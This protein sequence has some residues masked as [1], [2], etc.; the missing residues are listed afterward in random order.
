[1]HNIIFTQYC[2]IAGVG[3]NTRSRFEILPALATDIYFLPLFLLDFIFVLDKPSKPSY[4]T[5]LLRSAR[6]L[7]KRR[8]CVNEQR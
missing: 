1:M 8:L 2:A 3:D 5:H 4:F 7:K 6:V